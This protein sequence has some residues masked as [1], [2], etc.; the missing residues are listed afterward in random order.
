MPITEVS[1]AN[2][3]LIKVGA[4]RISSLTEDVRSAVLIN[5]IFDQMRDAVLRDHPWNFAEKRAVLAPTGTT[6]DFEWDYEYD[7]PSDCIRALYCY[8]DY[9][10]EID[11]KVVQNSKLYANESSVNLVYTFRSE[12]PSTWDASFAEAL[13]WRLA[14]EIAYAL[15][16]SNT[17]A[18]R[19]ERKYK[20]YLA[21]ARTSDGQEG[22]LRALNI[23]T[24][25]NARR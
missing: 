15:T 22:S 8:V 19:I 10:D 9:D 25:A 24:W 11:F 16:Q 20:E 23:S 7:L 18:D 17:T 13:A 12:D 1:I 21:E 2:S 6:P 4:D 14:G 3:A 5:A